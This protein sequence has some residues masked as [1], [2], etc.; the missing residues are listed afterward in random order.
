[1]NAD[2]APDERPEAPGNAD[3]GNLQGGQHNKDKAIDADAE[4]PV[5]AL[6]DGLIPLGGI[7]ERGMGLNGG[8]EQKIPDEIS[9][10][11][12]DGGLIHK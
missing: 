12:G 10:V 7:E 9:E 1:M 11:Q 4:E 6:F 5:L 2:G 3:G 8:G